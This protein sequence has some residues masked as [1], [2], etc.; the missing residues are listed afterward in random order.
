MI[1][2]LLRL[3]KVRIF[4][5]A[6]DES[7]PYSPKYSSKGFKIKIDKSTKGSRPDFPIIRGNYLFP[8]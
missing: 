8:P 4:P 2:Y 3:F 1:C 5:K 6:A 7:E